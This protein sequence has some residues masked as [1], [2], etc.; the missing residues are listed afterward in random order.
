MKKIL[1]YDDSDK[2][3]TSDKNKKKKIN[4]FNLPEFAHL[5]KKIHI[6]N[7]DNI[8]DI[9]I[10]PKKE[11]EENDILKL[12][13]PK[14][15]YKTY[16]NKFI[17]PKVIKAIKPIPDIEDPL[18][19]EKEYLKE[20]ES[21]ENIIDNAMAYIFNK[22]DQ[23]SLKKTSKIKE[24]NGNDL[25]DFDWKAYVQA[26]RFKKEAQK[27]ITVQAPNKNQKAKNQLTY[28]AFEAVSKQDEIDQRKM[29]ARMNHNSTQKK[30]GW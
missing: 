25:K 1:N 16:K 21:E 19:N 26:Q 14:N 11:I 20:E 22:K 24:I 3:D 28:L 13:K 7:D 5:R 2:S 17:D 23:K 8:K 9:K 18:I 6:E 12:S 10:I 4:L 15:E 30:Y 29:E 27:K